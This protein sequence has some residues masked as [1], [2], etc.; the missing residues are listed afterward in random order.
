VAKESELWRRVPVCR[1][2]IAVRLGRDAPARDFI[3]AQDRE[4]HERSG[5][6]R[7]PVKSISRRPKADY[8]FHSFSLP[9]YPAEVTRFPW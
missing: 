6:A 8:E 1:K 7:G 4:I 3:E 2:H 9:R 5:R